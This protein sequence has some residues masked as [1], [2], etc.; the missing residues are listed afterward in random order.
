MTFPVPCHDRV[1]PWESQQDQWLQTVKV[2]RHHKA[3]LEEQQHGLMETPSK[4]KKRKLVRRRHLLG[5]AAAWIVTVPASAVMSAI[6]FFL[7]RA[8]M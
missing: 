3:K 4:A 8:L 5:I 2:M 7:I 6:L 1:D